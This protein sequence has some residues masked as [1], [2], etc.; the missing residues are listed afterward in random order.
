MADLHVCSGLSAVAEGLRRRARSDQHQSRPHRLAPHVPVWRQGQ[1][2]CVAAGQPGPGQGGAADL[3]G[4]HEQQQAGGH[5]ALLLLGH[6]GSAVCAA[7]P[8]GGRSF[9][10]CGL[11]VL[12][13]VV[14]VIV[15][16][17]QRVNCSDYG[18]YILQACLLS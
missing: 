18:L 15:T 1:H 3:Q 17:N 9:S 14:H 4:G 12:I 11:H 2:H 13:A 5:P 7:A 10:S 16:G 6:Q 8:R